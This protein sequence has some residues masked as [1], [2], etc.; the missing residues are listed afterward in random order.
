MATPAPVAIHLEDTFK[1]KQHSGLNILG[2]QSTAIL[3][4]LGRVSL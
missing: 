1:P 4:N 3:N 2:E